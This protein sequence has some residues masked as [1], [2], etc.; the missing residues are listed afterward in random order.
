MREYKERLAEAIERTNSWK[1]KSRG[2]IM[3]ATFLEVELGDRAKPSP[4][5]LAE[6]SRGIPVHPEMRAGM[7][8]QLHTAALAMFMEGDFPVLPVLTIGNVLVD[9]EPRYRV[10]RQGLRRLLRK[11]PE[12]TDVI[13]VHMWLTWPDFSILDLTIL[14]ALINESGQEPTLDRPDGLALVGQPQALK[15]RYSYV[16]F[17]VGEEFIWRIGAVEEVAEY[18]YKHA[19]EVWFRRLGEMFQ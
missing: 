11:G 1:L 16:P 7:C 3:A 18:H 2:S 17:L 4:E 19:Q 6:F 12:A 14:P 5:A 8:A 9:G 15:P 13:H 10:S